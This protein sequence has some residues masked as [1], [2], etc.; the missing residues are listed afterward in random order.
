MLKDLLQVVLASEGYAAI[1]GLTPLQIFLAGLAQPLE[2]FL[3]KM[4]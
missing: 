3:L 4:S 1:S 2:K